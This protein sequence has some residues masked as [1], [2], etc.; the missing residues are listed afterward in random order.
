MPLTFPSH[1]AAVWP[2]HRAA[3]R[4][5]PAAALIVGSCTPDLAYLLDGGRISGHFSHS[6]R[7][8]VLFSIPV[9][10][11]VLAW[12]ELL[13][14]TLRRALAD[15]LERCLSAPAF[16]RTLRALWQ[17]SLALWLGALT[18]LSWDGFTHRTRWPASALYPLTQ[19]PIPFSDGSIH[20]ANLLQHVSTLLGLFLAWRW[21]QE[22][23][24]AAPRLTA[25]RRPWLCAALLAAGLLGACAAASLEPRALTAPWLLFWTVARGALLGVTLASVVDRIACRWPST[26]PAFRASR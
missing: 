3:P 14:P 4:V 5:L 7:G 10:L 2:L 20:L 15:P 22:V 9:G 25:Q 16:P 13:A 18:H 19:V 26:T 8:S 21:L 17:S 1:A 23:R 24:G 11:L 6:L 12:L